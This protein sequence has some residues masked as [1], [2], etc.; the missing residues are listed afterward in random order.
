M[1]VLQ[2]RFGKPVAFRDG[3]AAA[4]R[5]TVQAR[6]RLNHYTQQQPVALYVLHVS[7]RAVIGHQLL[8]W[9]LKNGAHSRIHSQPIAY[10]ICLL[11]GGCQRHCRQGWQGPVTRRAW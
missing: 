11:A 1:G 9:S 4:R 6:A 2:D 8:C 7:V 3:V 5:I 10:I